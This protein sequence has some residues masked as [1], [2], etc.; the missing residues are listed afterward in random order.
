M[1]FRGRGHAYAGEKPAHTH[2][3]AKWGWDDT[4]KQNTFTKSS[5]S[6]PITSIEQFKKLV[7]DYQ[8]YTMAD[9]LKSPY[10]TGKGA[11][12]IAPKLFKQIQD[13]LLATEKATGFSV[14]DLVTG[15]G[16]GEPGGAF[17]AEDLANLLSQQSGGSSPWSSTEAGVRY[18]E[19][20]AMA[21]MREE[22]RL[23][24]EREAAQRMEELKARRQQIFSELLGK[25][26]VR[27][28]L[29]GLGL[30]G[31]VPGFTKEETANLPPLEGIEAYK[32]NTEG[33]LNQAFQRGKVEGASPV[34]ITGEGIKGLPSGIKAQNLFT[35]GAG[36]L[37]GASTDLQT[38]LSSA[39]G[40]GETQGAQ[41]GAEGQQKALSPEELVR[42]I[43]DVTPRGIL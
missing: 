21:R 37:G 19:E 34:E 14:A 12:Q 3:R 15:G 6:K 22:Q 29:Y 18:A 41:Q 35:T 16:G 28:V 5:K 31:A 2:V 25:D 13:N 9:L 32:R 38:L 17:N 24:A 11:Y 40:V 8:N 7:P 33:A 42:Q 39:F 30:S 36:M 26:P 4:K 10:F 20:Q 43:Q 1:E 23:I 27:A